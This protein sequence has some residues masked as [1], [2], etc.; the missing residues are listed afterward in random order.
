MAQ[1]VRVM[2]FRKRLKGAGYASVSI[3][4]LDDGKYLVRAVEP[5]AGQQVETRLDCVDMC[6]MFRR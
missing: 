5:L 3:C 6:G 4:R 2:A 1:D